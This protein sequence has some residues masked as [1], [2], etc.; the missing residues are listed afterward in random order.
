MYIAHTPVDDGITK[1]WH[2][3]LY[4]SPNAV[5]TDEDVK[6]ARMAQAGSL[7]ALA[8]D[9]EI[10]TNKRACINPLAV[11]GDGA[12]GKIRQWYKQFYNPR[13]QEEKLQER[14]NG[15]YPVRGMPTSNQRVA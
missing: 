4:K 10:W 1:A 7:G 14:A 13:E 5:A 8:Q 3:F 11:P 6:I 12:F 15:T 2:G 9:F